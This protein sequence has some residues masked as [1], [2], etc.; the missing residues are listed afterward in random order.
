LIQKLFFSQG[1]DK[2]IIFDKKVY[3]LFKKNLRRIP[4][5][6]Q[7][8]PTDSEIIIQLM[9]QVA[10]LQ[11]NQGILQKELAELREQLKN[12]KHPKPRDINTYQF[13]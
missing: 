2:L 5:M 4:L 10:V 1:F 8:K 3:L 12:H 7:S 6:P 11:K 9:K 13:R